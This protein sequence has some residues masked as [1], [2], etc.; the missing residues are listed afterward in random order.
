LWK[1]IGAGIKPILSHVILNLA[2]GAE[3]HNLLGTVASKLL[4]PL[5]AFRVEKGA[6]ISVA[7]TQ[8]KEQGVDPTQDKNLLTLFQPLASEIFR[9]MGLDQEKKRPILLFGQKFWVDLEHKYLP[10]LLITI[11]ANSPILQNKAEQDRKKIKEFTHTNYIPEGCYI[12]AQMVGELIPAEIAVEKSVLADQLYDMAKKYLPN[13]LEGS[14][15]AQQEQEMKE[16]LSD[17]LSGLAMRLN[18]GDQAIISAK[19]VLEALFLKGASNLIAHI[20]SLEDPAGKNYREDF[21]AKTVLSLLNI[22]NN[23]IKKINEIRKLKNI[24]N[25]NRIDPEAMLQGYGNALHPAVPPEFSKE[26]KVMREAKKTINAE[27]LKISKT[28]RVDRIE[29]SKQ[30]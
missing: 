30:S 28:T 13:P 6:D 25:I 19:G 27:R 20:H 7:Y 16:L 26:R 10:Q 14:S 17:N 1:F 29:I 11:Y 24:S 8:V 23:H 22:V 15:S 18:E 12:L 21:V 9:I 3:G 2:E 4:N 5:S